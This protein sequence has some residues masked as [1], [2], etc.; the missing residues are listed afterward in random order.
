MDWTVAI[1][2]RPGSTLLEEQVTLSNHS[3]ARHHFFW[4]NNAGVEVWNDSRIYYPTQ[5]TIEDGAANIDTWP[6]NS[7]GKD[8]SLVAN[9]AGDFE[10]FAYGSS[11]PFM[12]VYSPHTDSGVVRWADPQTV[13]SK[14]LFAWGNDSNKL[15]WRNR[16]S[17]NH[18]WNAPQETWMRPAV[19]PVSPSRAIRPAY[20]CATRP[21]RSAHP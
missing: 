9:Q 16:L 5:F 10:A 17:D 4:W 15:D 3:D 21:Q 14:K 2:L 18:S 8:L 7:K 1:V 6:V 13:P 11:E 20:S 19:L 12:G